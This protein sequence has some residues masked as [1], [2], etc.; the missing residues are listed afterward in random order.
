GIVV[1]LADRNRRAHRDLVG[2]EL[3]LHGRHGQRVVVSQRFRGVA[4]A[5][6]TM[7]ARLHGGLLERED[8]TPFTLTRETLVHP[9][10]SLP[11]LELERVELV[12]A[13]VVI[14][15]RSQR[16]PYLRLRM[17][18]V[19]NVLLFA[20]RLADRG[21]EVVVAPDVYVP[22]S[23]SAELGELAARRDAVPPARV[24]TR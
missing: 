12:E 11:L 4:T 22:Q 13:D 15:K 20:Q 5:L 3:A 24:V 9:T 8:F 17:S 16:R 18:R 23:L 2:G 14:R 19:R 6:D 21:I 10:G 7:F 1:A